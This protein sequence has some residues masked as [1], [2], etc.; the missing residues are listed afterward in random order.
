M[1]KYSLPNL[2]ATLINLLVPGAGLALL[3]HWRLAIIAQ[4][5]LAL[6]LMLLCFSRLIFNPKF[7]ITLFVFTI[8]TYLVSTV[9]CCS[10]KKQINTNKRAN[11]L[12]TIAFSFCALAGLSLGFSYKDSWLGVHVYFVPS[13]SMFPTLKP[14]QFILVD[15][16]VYRQKMP[17]LKDVVVFT[18]GVNRQYLVKRITSWPKH[19]TIKQGF[20]FITGDNLSHS[21]DS[22]Y[23]GA[24]K[25][26]QIA[27]RALL[28]IA[29]VNKKSAV[30]IDI[31]LT[32]IE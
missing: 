25:T 6:P 20:W 1:I 16:W 26:A 3:G 27:G 29:V 21:Q 5:T 11:W 9:L 23:F 31:K 30:G 28:V 14:G 17:T 13:M 18:H 7:I 4:L 19:K 12:V 15:T 8:T 24:I 2:F 32:H 10:F 22:R